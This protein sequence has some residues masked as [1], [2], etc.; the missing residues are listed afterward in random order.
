MSHAEFSYE[1]KK[2]TL[3]IIVGTEGE[4]AIDIS[5]LRA[6]TGF[7]TLDEGYVNTG[8]CQSKI[9]F[10]DGEKGILRYR[11]YPIEEIS[12]HTDFLETSQLVIYGALPSQDD[13]D[14]FSKSIKSH[15]S[16]DSEI[17]RLINDFP[18]QAHPMSSL[19]SAS[20]CLSAYYPYNPKSE[21][22]TDEAIHSFLGRLPVIA[23]AIY[24]ARRGKE[25]IEPDPSLSYAG[26]FLRMM[27]GDE[28]TFENGIDPELARALDVLLILH[29]D[30]EQNCSTA[31][32]RIVSSS[33]VNLYASG[34][35]A[36]AALWGPL[37]G[38]ANQAVIEML[39]KIHHDG[40]NIGKYIAMAK[41][42][43]DS[44]RL[45]G[46]GHRVYK[47]FD[48]RASIIKQY[49]HTVLNKLGINDPLLELARKLEEQAL[50][51]DYFV[52]RKLFPNVD[53][54]SGI[55][56]KAMGIPTD[57][58]TVLFAMGRLPGWI[59]QWREL[60]QDPKL[61]IGRPRQIYQG[62]TK[63][64]LKSLVEAHR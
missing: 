17:F 26:N 11:G 7:V 52:S 29:A 50:S 63:R 16:I 5:K 2:I 59:A 13:Y 56:Y 30:H 38:G 57:M 9:T 49:A 64:T 3:P 33:Q 31:S 53:F 35:A 6:Q 43:N 4:T 22:E 41:D 28:K 51:D 23:A 27:F 47:N 46:F 39:T 44:F 58:F 25:H 55:I 1:G 40:D 62:Y 15:Y 36:M 24:R 14:H 34:S 10:I 37:H 12:E 18:N 48:P 32:M 19:I 21:Q 61:R 20:C 45:M 42:K 54:Y 8:S 60:M